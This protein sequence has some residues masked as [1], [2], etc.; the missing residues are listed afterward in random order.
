M[1]QLKIE[2]PSAVSS[3]QSVG[4]AKLSPR[5][6]A[7]IARSNQGFDRRK[8]MMGGG[9][10][11]GP[12]GAGSTTTKLTQTAAS[13]GNL[14][15]TQTQTA[16]PEKPHGILR[17][18]SVEA[19]SKPAR[20]SSKNFVSKSQFVTSFHPHT[21]Q[22]HTPRAEHSRSGT[23]AAAGNQGWMVQHGKI[24]P[25][26]A[27][28]TGEDKG[29]HTREYCDVTCINPFRPKEGLNYL[30]SVTHNRRRWSHVFPQGE[31]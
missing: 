15:Q 22:S 27:G 4:T 8:M 16:V 28:K 6:A 17:N 2:L 13:S 25:I 3:R 7:L 14:E 31:F 26:A 19:G 29:Q 18:S 24:I 11:R 1:P 30:Q 10:G 9:P 23:A 5:S 20:L 12:V 21:P